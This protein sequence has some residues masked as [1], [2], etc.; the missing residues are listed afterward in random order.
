MARF[1]LGT[2]FTGLALT[3]AAV[4]GATPAACDASAKGFH[5]GGPFKGGF[6]GRG[7]FHG[8]GRFRGGFRRHWGP[9]SVGP[10]GYP[11]VGGVACRS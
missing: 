8:H 2:A 9:A 4:G 11:Y 6:H 10:A 5:G 1:S 3:I 7:K